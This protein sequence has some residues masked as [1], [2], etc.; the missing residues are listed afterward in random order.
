MTGVLEH[1]VRVRTSYKG[2]GGF[3][4]LGVHLWIVQCHFN[5]DGVGVY[6]REALRDTQRIAIKTALHVEHAETG[7]TRHGNVGRVD[8]QR[9]TLPAPHGI[10]AEE[11]DIAANVRAA[12]ERNEPVLVVVLRIDR[13][14]SRPLR[15]FVP[16]IPD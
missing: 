5:R 11:P 4:G 16:D 13:N 10:A 2:A 6:R 8:H 12:V 3:P 1:L 15:D 7:G 14:V 9:L